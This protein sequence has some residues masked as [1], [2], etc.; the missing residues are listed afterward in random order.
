MLL[1]MVFST[2]CCGCGPNEPVSSLVHCV[3]DTNSH[4]VHKNTHRFLYNL[5]S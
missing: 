5:Y 1:H 4:T 3:S 2:E